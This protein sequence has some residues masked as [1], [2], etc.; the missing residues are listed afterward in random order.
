M[1]VDL[2]NIDLKLFKRQRAY[3]ASR[4]RCD[5]REGLMSLLDHVADQILYRDPPP[6]AV[7]KGMIEVIVSGGLVQ[8][9]LGL[10][11]D[12]DVTIKDY[13][14]ENYDEDQLDTDDEGCSFYRIDW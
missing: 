12:W 10:P 13:D 1:N 11:A 4:A 2:G 14:I 3:L 7:A 6:A 8:E 9:V 5:E